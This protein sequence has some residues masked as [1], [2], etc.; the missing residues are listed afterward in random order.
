[1]SK[2][3]QPEPPIDRVEAAELIAFAQSRLGAL[4]EARRP[5]SAA[6]PRGV[7]TCGEAD[8][9]L[10]LCIALLAFTHP[11]VSSKPDVLID[12]ALTHLREAH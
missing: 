8:Q 3:P 12:L 9:L 2:P 10:A 11:G 5:R 1:M 4:E 7:L 6:I